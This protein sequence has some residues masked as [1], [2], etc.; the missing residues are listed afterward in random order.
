MP[1]LPDGKP[2]GVPCPHLDEQWRCRLF[3]HP[4]RPAVC[5]SL[6]PSEEMCGQSRE[7]A[8]R[9]LGYLE[10]ETLPAQKNPSE[11]VSRETSA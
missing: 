5:G 9:W 11:K 10:A 7:Q 4:D 3:G 8:L 1:G 2:A 6:P